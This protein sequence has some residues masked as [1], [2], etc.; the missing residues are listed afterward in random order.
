MS[1]LFNVKINKLCFHDFEKLSLVFCLFFKRR[2]KSGIG[3]H[4]SK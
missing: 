3:F 2:L 1:N 4:F